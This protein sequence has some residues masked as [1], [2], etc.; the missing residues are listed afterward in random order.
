MRLKFE[1]YNDKD[2]CAGYML[3]EAYPEEL[4]IVWINVHETERG[5][6]FGS[7]LIELAKSY[8]KLKGLSRITGFVDTSAEGYIQR[9]RFFERFG[10]LTFSNRALS[11]IILP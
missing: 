4:H 11:F 1:I 7:K 5:K 8:A 2:E 10:K 6:G 3:L 9:K